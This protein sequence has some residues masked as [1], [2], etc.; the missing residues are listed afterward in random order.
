MRPVPSA[1]VQ[2]RL[3]YT[4]GA[5]RA[6]MLHARSLSRGGEVEAP[7]AVHHVMLATC[8]LLGLDPTVWAKW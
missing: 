8:T 5:G 1:H 4:V 6:G 2:R 7:G 3:Q